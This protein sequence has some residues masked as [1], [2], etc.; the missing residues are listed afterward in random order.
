MWCLLVMPA[1]P[2][3][4][5]VGISC[6]VEGVGRHTADGT[7][8]DAGECHIPG[9]SRAPT[10]NSESS[11]RK[12]GEGYGRQA[13]LGKQWV[14]TLAYSSCLGNDGLVGLFGSPFEAWKVKVQR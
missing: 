10:P 14:A 11:L 6:L 5:F 12:R 9:E 4:G 13:G 3:L 7:R 1:G 8:S 2:V